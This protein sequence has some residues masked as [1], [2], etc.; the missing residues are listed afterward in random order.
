MAYLSL[1]FAISCQ[2]MDML[3]VLLHFVR[4]YAIGPIHILQLLAV[5]SWVTWFFLQPEKEITTCTAGF[6][7]P[8]F[9][10]LYQ[11]FKLFWKTENLADNQNCQA[12]FRLLWNKI[13]LL[14]ETIVLF[15]S[16]YWCLLQVDSSF[17]F[18]LP[19]SFGKKKDIFSG[20]V[21]A[22]LIRET[23]CHSHKGKIVFGETFLIP[24]SPGAAICILQKLRGGRRRSATSQ[25]FNTVI[26]LDTYQFYKTWI[27]FSL[28]NAS[29][30]KSI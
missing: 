27:H 10:R 11:N 26:T 28:I 13:L 2:H 16:E 8:I 3:Q 22:D 24:A 12:E 23:P 7:L 6:V 9:F 17:Y 30:F 5:V 15:E 4:D 29:G 25:V 21:P 14:Q 1:T 19:I 20:L 18:W